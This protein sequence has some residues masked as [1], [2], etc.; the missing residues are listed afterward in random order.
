MMDTRLLKQNDPRV[1]RLAVDLLQADEVVAF[2]TD[3]VYGIGVRAVSTPAIEKLYQIKARSLD[4]PIPVMIAE[5]QQLERL[6]QSI[7]DSARRL[8]SQFWPGALTMVLPKRRDLPENLTNL[9][10]V[11]VRIPDHP[12]VLELLRLCGPL[13]VTSAN[14]SG[15]PEALDADAVMT[16]LGGRLALVVDGGASGGGVSSTVV[17]LSSGRIKILREGPINLSMIE[18][19]LG[20]PGLVSEIG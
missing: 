7:P 16:Q 8:A 19:A 9:P 6:V 4:K 12:F 1:L 17:D 5:V 3:T 14:L 15:Q 2:P 10:G 13:A 18:Q 11:G 20:D